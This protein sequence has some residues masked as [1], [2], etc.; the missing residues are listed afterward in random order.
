MFS[1]G[2]TVYFWAADSASI[3]LDL[4]NAGRA[5]G[6]AVMTA[7]AAT[8][9]LIRLAALLLFLLPALA[10][11]YK[12]IFRKVRREEAGLR[13]VLIALLVASVLFEIWVSPTRPAD[14]DGGRRD[15]AI[16]ERSEGADGT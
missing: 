6:N 8:L 11:L 1:L 16:E 12:Q 4:A 2:K 15:A 14:A 7:I 3:L 5:S 10:W 13:G 9:A